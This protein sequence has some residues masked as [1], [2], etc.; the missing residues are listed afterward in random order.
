MA[1]SS[2]SVTEN[3]TFRYQVGGW[4]HCAAVFP[5]DPEIWAAAER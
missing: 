4:V 5:S 3:G 1:T 2:R